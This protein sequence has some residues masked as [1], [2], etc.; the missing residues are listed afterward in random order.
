M[1]AGRI[2]RQSCDIGFQ[3]ARAAIRHGRLLTRALN[4]IGLDLTVL[5]IN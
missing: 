4:S 2:K 5:T 1:L 3:P